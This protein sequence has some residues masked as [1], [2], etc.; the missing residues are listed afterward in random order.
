[1]GASGDFGNRRICDECHLPA[2]WWA[3]GPRRGGGHGVGY[4]C[5]AHLPHGWKREPV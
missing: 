2:Q 1:M 4:F 3:T 5:G